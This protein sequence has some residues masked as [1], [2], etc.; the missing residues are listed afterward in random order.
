MIVTRDHR[1]KVRGTSLVLVAVVA[2]SAGACIGALA[3]AIIVGVTGPDTVY[4]PVP[5]A[6]AEPTRLEA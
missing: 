2:A 1:R 5:P 4:V 3:V 6:P